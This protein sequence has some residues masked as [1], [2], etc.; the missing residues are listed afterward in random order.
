MT[1]FAL[2]ARNVSSTLLRIF[3]LKSSFSSSKKQYGL[4]VESFQLIVGRSNYLGREALPACG[5]PHTLLLL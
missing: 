2:Q 4:A 1:L 3:R 5:P